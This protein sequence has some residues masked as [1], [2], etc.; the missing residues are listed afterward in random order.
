MIH[1]FQPQSS[2]D[3]HLV[4]KYMP[5]AWLHLSG[6]S[7][8][9]TSPKD[10]P[11][12]FSFTEFGAGIERSAV[13]GLV[14]RSDRWHQ[15]GSCQTLVCRETE[16]SSCRE[17]WWSA[18][19]ERSRSGD[20]ERESERGGGGEEKR[21]RKEGMRIRER[22]LLQFLILAF[23]VLVLP[24]GAVRHTCTLVNSPPLPLCS[25][26]GFIWVSVG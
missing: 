24:K 7:W 19:I 4:A 13:L 2:L 22:W 9:D 6:Y 12:K 5:F 20:A 15:P 16:G 10:G 26:D 1:P 25:W 21:E 23:V 11:I 18:C 14:E 3:G 8:L 17:S